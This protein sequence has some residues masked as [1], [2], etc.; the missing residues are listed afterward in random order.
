M[1]EQEFR[2]DVV[3]RARGYVDTR[4]KLFGRSREVGLDCGGLPFVVGW[5]V[6]AF[7]TAFDVKD[8]TYAVAFGGIWGPW[9]GCTRMP[10]AD[11]A[12]AD[13]LVLEYRPGSGIPYY[14]GI[15]AEQDGEL[16]II[17]ATPGDDVLEQPLG[18]LMGERELQGV[19]HRMDF[20][21]TSGMQT[22]QPN[23]ETGITD[24]EVIT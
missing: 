10:E 21:T 19:V 18:G 7:S 2:D 22:V 20:P 24:P 8:Y 3:A 11:K 5:E 4:F 1:N 13:I 14:C 17:H 12:P 6:G 15:L 23:A 9:A 16:T